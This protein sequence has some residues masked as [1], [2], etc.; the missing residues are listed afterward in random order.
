MRQTRWLPGILALSVFA[1]SAAGH[2]RPWSGEAALD[3]PEWR[4]S[5]LGSYGFLSGAEPK[6]GPAELELLRDVLDLMK[7]NPRAAATMLE[8]QAGENSSAALDF[9]LAN[10]EFQNG[11]LAKA[12]KHYTMAL[13]KFPD[14]RR[15]HKNLGLLQVQKGRC[16]EALP[17]LTRAVELGDRDGRNYGLL[18][19][20]HLEGENHLASESAYRSAILQQPETRDWKLGLS[21]VLMAMEQYR[22]AAALLTTLIDATPD[23]A[24]LWL[25]QAN[26]HVGLGEPMAAAVDLEVVRAM[27][28]A[29]ASSLVLLGDIYMN[30]GMS[31]LAKGAYLEVI[32]RDGSGAKFTTAYRAA[33]LLIR[34]RAYDQAGEILESIGKRYKKLSQDEELRVLTL[35][36]KLARAKGR[37]S[38]AAK[39]LA[40]IVQRDGTRG[41][42]LLE[43]AAH[44]QGRGDVERAVLYLERAEKLD[45]FEYDALLARAQLMASER[46]YA[47]AAALLR[48]A[49]Q[50][51]REPRVELYLARVEEAHRR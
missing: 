3:D 34:T 9:I 8:Q 29:Q 51:R 33:D 15:A 7:A 45:E 42:A 19:Y 39:L 13:E 21:R 12:E 20:C 6:A 5:F 22:E 35:R 40:S 48:R 28:K 25:L 11:E 46:D 30:E 44:H 38:E 18:G 31:E 50:I 4:K 36:A 49:L 27:G 17:H 43:L 10:L 47:K 14:F 41:D 23:D 24:A 2:A 32:A 16:V 26:A 1:A 37:N